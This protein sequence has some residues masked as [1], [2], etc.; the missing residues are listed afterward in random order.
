MR[1]LCITDHSDRPETETF[2][3]LMSEGVDIEVMCP[4]SAPL[5]EYLIKSGVK[6]ID[7][8]LK[9]RIDL[10]AVRTIR[11]RV[12]ER[13]IDILHGFNN[14]A[15]SN[16]VLSS[17]G[18]PVKV[19]AYRGTIG[20]VSFFD[21]GSWLTYLNPKVDRVIC[22]SNAVLNFFLHMKLLWIKLNPK[23]F[24]TIYKNHSIDWYQDPPADLAEFDI[25]NNAFVVI[26][27]A[28]ARPHK[29]IHVLIEAVKYLPDNLPIHIL[30]VGHMDASSLIEKIKDNPKREK[31]HLAGY[32][33]NAPSIIA[34][35][36]VFVFPVLRREGLGKV[37]IEAM[38]CKVPPI[39]TSAGGPSELI[40]HNHSGLI[41]PPG[42][43]KVLASSIAY[44]FENPNICRQMGKNAQEHIRSH[45]RIEDTIKKTYALYNELIIK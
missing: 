44:L 17:Y 19:V 23:K 7:F 14:K 42:N 4:S 21:P 20:N 31:I 22:L 5:F 15:V 45:F 13:Q 6:V 33:Q 10:G 24:V 2:I 35:S 25:P 29:G 1:V 26:C 40:L 37:I 43:P 8:R 27:V 28:N 41:V 16:A 32:R 3:G 36:D 11:D 9:S 18:L 12:K 39:V 38:A 34:A 30:I